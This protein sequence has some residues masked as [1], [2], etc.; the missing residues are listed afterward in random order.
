[1]C[2][3]TLPGAIEANP[4]VCGEYSPP[5]HAL[6][7]GESFMQ[8]KADGNLRQSLVLNRVADGDPYFF[9]KQVSDPH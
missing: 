2:T 6:N 9:G 1:M 8:L 3:G 7:L 4:E 5:V